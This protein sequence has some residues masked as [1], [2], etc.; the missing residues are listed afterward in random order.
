MP[1]ILNPTT[2]KKIATV[3]DLPGQLGPGV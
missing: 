2:M 1:P 3:D